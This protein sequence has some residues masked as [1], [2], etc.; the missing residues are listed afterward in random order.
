MSLVTSSI[1]LIQV[2]HLPSASSYYASLTQPLSIRYLSATTSY[3]ATLHFGRLTPSGPQVLFSLTQSL[4]PLPQ[5]T[6]VVLPA[7]NPNQI[8]D[9]YGKGRTLNPGCRDTGVVDIST[10]EAD[11]QKAVTRDLD[12]NLIE[13]VYSVHSG[14]GSTASTEKEARRVLEWQKSVADSVSGG[15]QVAAPRRESAPMRLVRRQTITETWAPLLSATEP[16]KSQSNGIAGTGISGGTIIGT[17]LGAAAGA[18]IAYAMT[19]SEEPSPPPVVEVIPSRSRVSAREMREQEDGVVAREPRYVRYAIAPAPSPPPLTRAG[20]WAGVE[21]KPQQLQIDTRSHVSMRSSASHRSS[22]TRSRSEHPAA[23]EAGSRF[24]RPLTI[25]PAPERDDERSHVSNRTHQSR[26]RSHVS[27]S[28]SHASR[29]DVVEV[30]EARSRHSHHHSD[31]DDDNEDSKSYAHSSHSRR[32]RHSKHSKSSHRRDESASESGTFA[33]A[34]SHASS[35]TIKASKQPHQPQRR[36][37]GSSR[38][39]GGATITIVGKEGTRSFNAHDLR[40]RESSRE[41]DR[42]RTPRSHV[43]AR[44]VPLPRSMVSARDVP[45]P[46]SVVSARDVPLPGSTVSSRLRGGRIK[47]VEYN[48]DGVGGW[49]IDR[50]GNRSRVN[51]VEDDDQEGGGYGSDGFGGEGVRGY[52]ASVAP[53]DSVS[54]VGGK[55]ERERLRG[56]MNSSGW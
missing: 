25:Q 48:I 33:S 27:G 56:R 5:L 21:S 23:S 31:D 39:E 18:T 6:T 34:R 19:R 38:A 51:A 40:E 1:P 10:A 28:R 13:A 42:H 30:P 14:G 45:L 4:T 7:S 11:G 26:A 50:H 52:A 24:D 35:S 47:E 3:P 55:R 16:Q 44:N 43:S 2:S 12:G 9:F 20:T 53:S 54:C 8:Q 36:F 32:S 29:R 17:L 46:R 15:S 37:S 41:R 49:R 22:K